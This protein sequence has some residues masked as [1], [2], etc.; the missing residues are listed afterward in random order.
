MVH[1]LVPHAGRAG[2]PAIAGRLVAAL[3]DGSLGFPITYEEFLHA[4]KL[5]VS[6][7]DYDLPFIP[8]VMVIA[9]IR[10]GMCTLLSWCADWVSRRERRSPRPGAWRSPR[11][12]RGRCC[13][14]GCP[15]TAPRP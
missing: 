2:P 7:L 11:P 13:R 4:G 10:V 5:I 12:G 1:V 6:D 8:V 15:P 9:P 14:V 3:K